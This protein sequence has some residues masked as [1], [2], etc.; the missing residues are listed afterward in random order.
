MSPMNAS[1]GHSFQS[2]SLWSSG[3]SLWCFPTKRWDGWWTIT[4]GMA[5]LQCLHA[6]QLIYD[7]HHRALSETTGVDLPVSSPRT[8]A[9]NSEHGLLSGFSQLLGDFQG[10]GYGCKPGFGTLNNCWNDGWFLSFQKHVALLD[11]TA[12]V[13]TGYQD[14]V[15]NTTKTMLSGLDPDVV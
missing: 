3:E 10:Y 1:S 4:C 12:I 6:C 11:H 15:P 2:P 13:S 14:N 8:I 5:R 9:A 7:R